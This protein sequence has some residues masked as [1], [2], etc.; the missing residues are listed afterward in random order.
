MGLA[1]DHL[2]TLRGW[3]PVR[4]RARTGEIDWALVDAPLTDPFFEQ[5]A[6]RAM[7][8][9]FNAAF[10]RRSPLSALEAFDAA[11]VGVAPSGF[12]FHMSRCGSTLIAQMLA[13]LTA[14]IVLSEPQPIDAVLRLRGRGIDDDTLARWLRGM[15]SALGQPL[16]AERRL[17][18]KF[19]AW[20][21]LELPFIARAFPEVPWLFVFREPRDVLRSQANSPGAE[22]VLGT[23]DPAYVGVDW[24]AGYGIAPAEYAARAIAAFCNAAVRHA[25]L[26]R[27][28]FIDY[29]ALPDGVF[30]RLLGAFGVRAD[31]AEIDR[32]RDVA[33]L[34]AKNPGSSFRAPRGEPD[35]TGEIERLAAR[36]VDAPYAALRDAAL[37]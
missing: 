33:R 19:H 14:T 5:T 30:S 2:A 20:H 24:A 36:W 22:V 37:R 13:R 26:G 28:T 8:H 9:P 31:D 15:L 35:A 29:A 18:V 27:S 25:A 16:A 7:Q 6:H 3:T 4:V 32:M 1:L 17:F 11:D 34:D 23:I 12:I 21:V 10:A